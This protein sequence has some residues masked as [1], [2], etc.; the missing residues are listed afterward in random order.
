MTGL[1]GVIACQPTKE[2]KRIM[3]EI[4]ILFVCIAAAYYLFREKG[5]GLFTGIQKDNK[6]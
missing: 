1:V 3:I 5:E 4:A 6:E 2:R